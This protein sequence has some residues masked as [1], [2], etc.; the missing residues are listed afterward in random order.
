MRVAE[1]VQK[2]YNIFNRAPRTIV[3]SKRDNNKFSGSKF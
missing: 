2:R 1:S 3:S